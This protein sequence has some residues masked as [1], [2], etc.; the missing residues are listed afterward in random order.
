MQKN[1][2]KKHVP[3]LFLGEFFHV[4]I[5]LLISKQMVFLIQFEINFYLWVLK[6]LKLHSP[7]RIVQFQLFEK[8]TR[9]NLFQIELETVWL[10][11]Q[12]DDTAY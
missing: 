9:A 12:I 5:Y 2:F 3:A 11:I 8:L 7:K 4:C 1:D 6:K 10:L